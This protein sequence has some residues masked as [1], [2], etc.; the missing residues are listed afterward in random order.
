ME[1]RI[2]KG[3]VNA[4]S[5]FIIGA[6]FMGRWYCIELGITSGPMFIDWMSVVVCSLG[7]AA[8]QVI[9]WF[10]P[11]FKEEPK[12]HIRIVKTGRRTVDPEAREE[13]RTRPAGL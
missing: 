5:M 13:E 12:R 4:L 3:F 7:L 6:A 9:V 11:S 10:D 1:V 8:I 2:I